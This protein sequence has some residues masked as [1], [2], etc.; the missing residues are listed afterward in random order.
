MAAMFLAATAF[1]ATL[2]WDGG[3]VNI[4]T[5][6]DGVSAGGTGTWTNSVSNWDQGS[7]LP[8]T[9][10][11]GGSDATF[12]GAVGTISTKANFSVGTLTLSQA[13]TNIFK[14]DLTYPAP[15][16]ITATSVNISSGATLQFGSGGGGNQGPMLVL[17]GNV[18][19][20]GTAAI[21]LKGGYIHSD[22]ATPRAINVATNHLLQGDGGRS[23]VVGDPNGVGTGTVTWTG[24][25]DSDNSVRAV[26][27]LT[28]TT[29]IFV[30]S[31]TG[32][33]G[34]VLFD[35][36]TLIWD[37][38]ITPG[39][40]VQQGA[41]LQIGNGG[42]SGTLAGNLADTATVA[43]N[44]SDA[45][46][47]SGV[48][49]GAA[50]KVTKLGSG[51]LTFNGAHT[52]T[53]A[54]TISSGTLVLGASGNI[55]NSTPITVA[56]G[57]QFDISASAFALG[58]G[59]TLN[60]GRS[61]AF[62]TD[63][64][65]SLASTGIIQPGGNGV[66]R[67]MTIAGDLNLN[68]GTLNFDL[69]NSATVGGGVNDLITNT[70]ALNLSGA[71]TINVNWLNGKPVPGTYTLI[72]SA[73]LGSGDTNNF[74]LG[75]G[76][77]G[78][79]RS[80][81]TL[82]M[83][84]TPG[85]VKLVIVGV[86]AALVWTNANGN[87]WDNGVT[88]N[89]LNGGSLDAFITGDLAIFNDTPASDQTINAT[90]TLLSGS[91]T[92]SNN[93][94]N[95][96]VND[97]GTGYLQAGNLSKPGSANATIASRIDVSGNLSV[98]GGTLRLAP[99]A[100]V[101]DTISGPVTG[102][103]TLAVG[104]AGQVVVSSANNPYSGPVVISQAE[105]MAQANN[106]LGSSTITL[107]DAS[108]TATDNPT[109]S[110]DTG[111]SIPNAVVVSAMAA[112]AT[113]GG[114]G[115]L[116]GSASLTKNG[117]GTLV[118]QNPNTFTGPTVINAGT[119]QVDTG[120]GGASL[121][122]GPVTNNASLVFFRDDS[123]VD[124]IANSISGTGTISFTNSG[125]LIGSAFSGQ[126]QLAGNN[127]NFTG[128]MRLYNARIRAVTSADNFGS[129]SMIYVTSNSAVYVTPAG[130]RFTQP[131][132]IAGQGWYDTAGANYL[133]ALRFENNPTWAGPITLTDNARIGAYAN[134]GTVSGPIN[135]AYELEIADGH[136][137]GASTMTMSNTVN[138]TTSTRLTTFGGVLTVVLGSSSALSTGPLV[139]G[140]NS[141]LRL[142]GNNAAFATLTATN[143]TIGNGNTTTPATFTA[144]ANN[145]DIQFD[146]VFTNIGSA[147]LNVTKVG[148]GRMILNGNNSYTGNTTVS[149][150]TLELAQAVLATNSAV[151][152]ASGA[153]L[154]LDFGVTN[155]VAG[156]VLSGVS[157]APGVYNSANT[158]P[159]LAGTGSLLVQPIGPSGP[160]HLTNSVSGGILSLS[161]PA[162]Q[163]W[164]LQMQTNGLGTNWVY[165]T[166]GTASSTN[167]TVNPS[168]TTVFFRLVY[169]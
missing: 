82:D 145:A 4:G 108:T 27:V 54:T 35:A 31:F 122:S 115:G 55:A 63:I 65:G 36:G 96:T 144:G 76:V 25:F 101:V 155:Q 23:L 99:G 143:V 88:T 131:V 51:T 162:G 158:A 151:L 58:T 32:A 49:S 127:T 19:G 85:T 140:D 103:G 104:G 83:T 30:G 134:S 89:W 92:F 37:G 91:M 14:S 128:V 123:A 146:G 136:P 160:A 150:G 154:Q 137:T 20:A 15:R 73:S 59:Q 102:T 110:I 44:R 81:I 116:G 64:N 72:G 47:Y 97:G 17:A 169:P 3:T 129:P 163:G 6:G 111:F 117:N 157:Q 159:Y 2:Y 121:G 34:V 87:V 12:A 56:P 75:T 43:F 8:H 135:G 26:Q 66:A 1:S 16:T 28:N 52:Y 168:I 105:L 79:G 11:I 33:N 153:V 164:K 18:T 114:G 21:N 22:S 112:N 126:F 125:A 42:A 152:I 139:M 84:S 5:N 130:A 113:L 166:D 90:G 45:Y 119:L 57:A 156:L 61:S 149:A 7:G 100:S 98:A 62:A 41:T 142:N 13:G 93:V 10:W 118:V 50:G 38:D 95:F 77:N 138:T 107:G 109:L 133:G 74:I 48:I 147:P 9:N 29:A 67:T 69:T 24:N 141:V 167:I 86:P 53:G 39:L 68:G 106:A 46:T 80:S 94:R 161:W 132:S 124:N 148:T 60:A 78:S 71:T 120:V 165:L 70:G 40:T